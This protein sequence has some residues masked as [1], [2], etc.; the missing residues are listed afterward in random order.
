MKAEKTKIHFTDEYI[1]NPSHPITVN[2]IGVGGTGSQVLTGLGRINHALNSLG[3]PGLHVK[4]FDP[5]EVTEANI[6]RQL[7]PYSDI[8]LNK[9]EVLITRINRFFG[10]AWDAIPELFNNK[11]ANITI[12]CVDNIQSRLSVS[13]FLRYTR[14]YGS[15]ITNCQ[16]WLDFGN[17]TDH[18]QYVLGTVHKIKQPISKKYK[19]V[20]NLRTATEMFDYTQINEEDSGPSC[21]L[22]EALLKQDLFINS[23][24]AEAGCNLIWRLLRHG[25]INNQGAFINLSTMHSNPINL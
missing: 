16:Y 14:N 3:K 20:S 18:G 25:I 15:P 11:A 1:V 13:D 24:L 7:F 19:T 5:D 4:A 17:T 10:T 2:L 23:F 22:S 9:A 6:G 8:G 21:S 12:T